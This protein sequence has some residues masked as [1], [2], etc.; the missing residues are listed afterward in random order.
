VLRAGLFDPER[1]RVA[2]RELLALDDP[3]TAIF[4]A[5]DLSALATLEVAAELGVEVPARLS[6]VGFD[7]LPES[8]VA[9]PPLTTVA[10]PIRQMGHDAIE[11]LLALLAGQTLSQNRETLETTLVVRGSTAGPHDHGA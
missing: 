3:P 4:A 7:N 8:A 6:V 11:M 5:N 2:A 10:Q 9:V 1:A